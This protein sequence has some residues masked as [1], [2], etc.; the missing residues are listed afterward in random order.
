MATEA[1][2]E[3]L[4]SDKLRV[5][6]YISRYFKCNQRESIIH[7]YLGS[8][9]LDRMQSDDKD[10]WME[11][12]LECGYNIE[13]T[14]PKANFKACLVAKKRT[15]GYG[16]FAG[17]TRSSIMET[18][19]SSFASATPSL[20]IT[21]VDIAICS[22][23]TPLPED[24]GKVCLYNHLSI[25]R[26]IEEEGYDVA[27]GEKYIPDVLT[28]TKP[29]GLDDVG[30][31]KYTT[32]CETWFI[33][34][35][36][37]E[38]I[39]FGTIH[40]A[41]QM[42]TLRNYKTFVSR[43]LADNFSVQVSENAGYFEATPKR[44]FGYYTKSFII[45][46]LMRIS[47]VYD[48]GSH[49]VEFLYHEDNYHNKHRMSQELSKYGHQ[50]KVT[51]EKLL[52]Y[53]KT[54]NKNVIADENAVI[55]MWMDKLYK[56]YTTDSIHT[57]NIIYGTNTPH[58]NKV[59]ISNYM[60][61]VEVFTTDHRYPP[62]I[63]CSFEPGFHRLRFDVDYPLGKEPIDDQVVSDY[64]VGLK[65]TRWWSECRIIMYGDVLLSSTKTVNMSNYLSWVSEFRRKG[66]TVI[67]DDVNRRMRVE[68]SYQTTDR[69][70]VASPT[71]TTTAT[72]SSTTSDDCPYPLIRD[73]LLVDATVNMH[74]HTML[75]QF[76]RSVCQVY[77]LTPGCQTRE[78]EQEAS[79]AK[80]LAKLKKDGYVTRRCYAAYPL[81]YTVVMPDP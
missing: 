61:F 71:T 29:S 1:K 74:Y 37:T 30:D 58:T 24:L 41:S 78:D 15:S 32:F 51:R 79:I 39:H 13:Y 67:Q 55:T 27:V 6:E 9:T 38:R 33:N 57:F 46:V 31:T 73:E 52:V 21:S 23:T 49:V 63:K 17:A 66:F 7:L 36:R 56:A 19:K 14:P 26:F 4:E 34:S 47:D 11:F 42:V 8:S 44:G 77:D 76:Y 16:E 53:P 3:L 75:A 40:S 62:F 65:K 80:A 12:L 48:M 28:I 5:T 68:V 59:N 60:R 43:L 70:D 22:N 81:S 72:T 25:K 18:I 54:D 64:I 45:T 69:M 50:C 35:P 10:L 2:K 20:P